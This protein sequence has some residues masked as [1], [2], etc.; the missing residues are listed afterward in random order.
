MKKPLASYKNHMLLRKVFIMTNNLE[1]MKKAVDK[2]K[3]E[4][5]NAIQY[6]ISEIISNGLSCIK[7]ENGSYYVEMKTEDELLTMA[8]AREDNK[9]FMRVKAVIK[10]V[11]D[12]I[13]NALYA[14]DEW[15]EVKCH[16]YCD[17]TIRYN[18]KVDGMEFDYEIP[19]RYNNK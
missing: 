18:V 1:A 13:S 16:I 12:I 14:I 4:Y 8:E 15:T 11:A 3:E 5:R 6:E 7:I 2:A 9:V 19:N 17:N 10:A